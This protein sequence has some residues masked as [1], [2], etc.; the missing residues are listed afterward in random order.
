M[1]ENLPD[2]ERWLAD[3]G[4][5]LYRHALLRIRDPHAAED[6]VQETLLA[7]L[8]GISRFRR[9]SSLKTWLF[10]ILTHKV[11]DHFR[12]LSRERPL[13]QEVMELMTS[14]EEDEGARET[15]FSAPNVGWGSDPEHILERKAFQEK[16]ME[17]VS[18]LK[19]TTFKVFTLR[20]FEGMSTEEICNVMRI[21][22][23]NLRV[24]LHRAREQICKCLEINWFK[25]EGARP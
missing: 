23:T 11:A 10:G 1:S 19:K 15:M 17:C 9:D 8:E 5:L 2:S 3:Y 7:A 4:D 22:P 13:E 21:T 12:K 16:L 24:I 6:L 18:H 14:A 25:D 20:E